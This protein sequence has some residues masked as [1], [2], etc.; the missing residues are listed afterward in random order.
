MPVWPALSL[1]ECT[2]LLERLET[3]W[4]EFLHDL[5][6][7]GLERAFDYVNSKGVAWSSTVADTLMHLIIHAAYHRGQIALRIRLGGED[8]PYTDFIQVTREGLI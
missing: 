8:P 3:D 1:D 6:D 7:E 4:S 2:A 5:S